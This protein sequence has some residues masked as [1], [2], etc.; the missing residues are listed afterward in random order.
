M[1]TLASAT[2]RL[3]RVPDLGE[4]SEHLLAVVAMTTWHIDPRGSHRAAILAAC[5]HRN[6]CSSHM[7]VSEGNYQFG[8]V[9]GMLALGEDTIRPE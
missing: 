8:L 5:D 3:S 9:E 6:H 1:G 2:A 4:D 7:E